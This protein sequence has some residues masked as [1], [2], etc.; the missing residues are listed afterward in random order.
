MNR[1]LLHLLSII[2]VL[3]IA[4]TSQPAQ[5][6]SATC[7]LRETKSNKILFHD[8]CDFEQFGGNGSFQVTLVENWEEATIP[9]GF[10]INIT[11]NGVGNLQQMRYDHEPFNL[12]RVT[13]SA[14][15]KACWISSEYTIC[16]YAR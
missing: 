9:L 3:F 5:A 2:S 12:G 7:I 13:R 14:A 15:D 11:G 8:D 1:K 16:A 4:Q 6:A 10:T